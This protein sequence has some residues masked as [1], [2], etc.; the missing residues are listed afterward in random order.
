MSG[1]VITPDLGR[2]TRRLIVWEIVIV[3]AVAL[4]RSAIY[5]IITLV[6]R[7]TQPTPLGQQTTSMN[8]S[9]TPDRPWLDLA[10]QVYYVILP[11]AQVLL[12]L[13]LL[14][15]AH[16]QARRLIGF[17]LTKVGPD[18]VKGVGMLLAVGIPGLGFYLLARA[19]GIN[20]NVVPA[21][22]TAVWWTIPILLV[23]AAM[24]GISE[25]T[26]MIGY[27]LTRLRT[28]GWNPFV[29]IVVSALIRG[30][31]HLYQ[32][33]G[34]AIGNLVMGLAFGL[35]FLKWKR[36][37]PFVITHFLIDAFAFVGYSLLAP[38]VSWL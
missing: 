11:V 14:H 27:L 18:L 15:L 4:G 5:S 25:E 32:G 37:M 6:D 29:A 21:N 3:M 7:L 24:A 13:Y 20:T 30:S 1:D 23:N 35:L 22:L 9:V 38:Y 16:G 2:S 36:V 33:W 8:N 34:G 28:L 12:I 19:I 26:I 17:D 31:Y 10:Y